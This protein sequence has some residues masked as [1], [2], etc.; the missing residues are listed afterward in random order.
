MPF[1][2][3]AAYLPGTSTVIFKDVVFPNPGHGEVLLKVKSSTIC[4]SDIRAIYREHLGKVL[5]AIRTRYVVTNHQV[6]SLHVDL[7]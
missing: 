4:G 7:A 6:K 3:K 2:S 5:K 1:K